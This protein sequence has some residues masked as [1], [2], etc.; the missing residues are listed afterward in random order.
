VT[1]LLLFAAP[2]FADP[3]RPSALNPDSPAFYLS[4]AVI[5]CGEA[6]F[7]WWLFRRRGL[8]QGRTVTIL[9]GLNLATWSLFGLVLVG[10]LNSMVS[11]LLI[12]SAIVLIEAVAIFC[13]AKW[14]WLHLPGHL[15]VHF[16][17]ALAASVAGNI[18]SWA[19]GLS[20]VFLL[21]L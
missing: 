15:P 14:T 9:I 12:E 21:D 11:F 5:L 17:E 10:W 16:G 6:W 19:I 20:M 4:T 13:L 8:A 18:L 2:A 3:L 1:A 7:V